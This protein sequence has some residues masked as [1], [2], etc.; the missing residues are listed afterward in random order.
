MAI[1]GFERFMLPLLRLAADGEEHS[2]GEA[3]TVLALQFKLSTEERDEL[4]PSG[5][6]TRLKNRIA[7]A[8]TYLSKSVLIERTGRGRFRITERGRDVL[9]APPETID[10]KF[11]AQ[12]PE[13]QA[14]RSKRNEAS[15]APTTSEPGATP[16][17]RLDV[18]YK[19]LNDALADELLSRVRSV[20][21]KFFEQLVVD[22]LVAMGYGGS[23]VDA[24]Q[25]VG[26]SGDGGIDGTIKE[27][28]LGLDVIYVQAKRWENPVGRKEIQSFAGSLDG[29]RA[30]KGVFITT[31]Q[32]S[33][34]A[35]DYVRRIAKRIVL[36][37]GDELA[38]FMIDHGVGV[39]TDRTI[40]VRRVDGDYFENE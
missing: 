7:W 4:L 1:P 40:L 21:P 23:R 27:D 6:M 33:K 30:T 39:S 35:Q 34:E 32:F 14:F 15:V 17:E 12:Y 26:K 28:R 10:I 3:I 38:A 36:I 24:A 18:A 2:L 11:L 31:S 9:H 29:E 22:V 25:V 8:V 37:D 20:S 5:T 16:L 13:L 19:E